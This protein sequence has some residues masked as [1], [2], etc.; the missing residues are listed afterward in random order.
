MLYGSL[1]LA[2][3][4]ARMSFA[5]AV[6]V[7]IANGQTAVALGVVAAPV[8]SLTVVPLAFAGRAVSQQDGAASPG[9]RRRDA[10]SRWPA[11]AASRP[12]CS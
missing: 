5:L 9:T 6:A 1:L 4:T 8:L 11:A 2:E 12:R 10:S 7:G 3:S